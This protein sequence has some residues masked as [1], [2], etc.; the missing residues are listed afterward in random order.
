MKKL[1]FLIDTDILID[2]LVTNENMSL[3]EK[4]MQKGNCF[5]SA[6]NAS[7]LYFSAKD[8]TSK[9]CVD[10]LLRALKVLGINS[11]YSLSICD[12][13]NKTKKFR[14]AL[15][16]VIADKNNL[17]IC[18]MNKDSYSKTGIELFDLNDI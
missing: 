5:T 1:E 10:K 7:E 17:I 11:R 16:C 6:I 13:N 12:Y 14:D 2:H 15:F 18:T 8:K 9:L 3:L 4:I